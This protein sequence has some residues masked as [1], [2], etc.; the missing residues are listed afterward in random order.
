M[1][2]SVR[3]GKPTDLDAALDIYVRARTAR[4][5]GRSTPEFVRDEVRSG[6]LQ[7]TTW[8]FMAF[9]EAVPVGMAVAMPSREDFGAGPIIP[10]VC[11]LGQLFVAPEY[12]GRGIGLLLL[13]TVIG[14]AA[15]RGYVSMDLVVNDDNE[16][17]QRLYVRRGFE[18]TGRS[19]MSLDPASGMASEWVRPLT[20]S[21][22]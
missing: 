8:F 10:G 3:P 2:L 15:R 11:H 19:R 4:N 9:D 6:L 17:A 1:S 16:R 20:A 13:D 18:P 21:R 14:E 5:P 12:W 22:E 7:A